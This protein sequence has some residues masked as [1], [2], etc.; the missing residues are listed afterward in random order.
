MPNSA[1]P[2]STSPENQL[3]RA[4]R[5]HHQP[6]GI[7]WTVGDVHPLGF[8]ALRLSV[9][10]AWNLFGSAAK[11]VV[12]VNSMPLQRAQDLAGML[13]S[14]VQW[15]DNSDDLPGWM[16]EH[17][18]ENLT[19]GTAWKLAPP[20][21]FPDSFELAL[22]NDCIL[23]EL[24]LALRQW[25]EPSSTTST[26]IAADTQ[27]MLGKFADLCDPRP[28]NSGIRG[29][30]PNFGF[31]QRLQAIL[32]EQTE[33]LDSE[34]DEQG[35]QVAAVTRECRYGVVEVDEVAIC[36]PF[37]HHRQHLGRCGAHFVGLNAWQLPWQWQ[38]RAASAW[39]R[40]FWLQQRD[41][42]AQRVGVPEAMPANHGS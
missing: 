3:T 4:R 18:A 13:P 1:S 10:G 5:P 31:G 36:S 42:I 35:L 29:L 11:Y 39:T 24:P 14:I 38:G 8:D 27:R 6:L 22:D 30:P 21:L 2:K 25:L 28:L 40:E 33:R 12:C 7:R 17:L 23:W 34:L 16:S 15:R 19:E 20:R 37:P 9:W 41:T 26:L 32:A